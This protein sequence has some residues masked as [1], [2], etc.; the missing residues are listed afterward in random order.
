MGS[1]SSLEDIGLPLAVTR[2]TALT[3][4]CRLPPEEAGAV[5]PL[6]ISFIIR[7]YGGMVMVASRHLTSH[8]AQCVG[9]VGDDEDGG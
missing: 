4:K 8:A 2:G 7:T 3:T 6:F 5:V 9:E 1:S